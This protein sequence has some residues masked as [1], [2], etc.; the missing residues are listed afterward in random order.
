M[1]VFNSTPSGHISTTINGSVLASTANSTNATDTG[2]SQGSTVLQDALGYTTTVLV[3]IVMV[4]MG[5]ATD[6]RII[7]KH[8]KKPTGVVIGFVCQFGR[9]HF[10]RK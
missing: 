3:A 6:V 5:C 1:E 2:G 9:L 8:L 7:M 10:F 4:G